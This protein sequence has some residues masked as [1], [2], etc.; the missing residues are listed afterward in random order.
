MYFNGSSMDVHIDS[1]ALIE[2]S[3][4]AQSGSGY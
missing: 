3:C 4:D 1:E 2:M